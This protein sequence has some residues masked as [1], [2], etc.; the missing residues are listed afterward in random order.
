MRKKENH[1]LKDERKYLPEIVLGGIDGSIT[2]FAVVSG[3]VG[4]SLNTSIVLIMG[5]AN[6]FADGFSMAVSDFFSVKSNNDTSKICPY[7][8]KNKTPTQ[9]AFATFL[10]FL[11]I[12]FIPLLSFVFS[13]ITKNYFIVSNQFLISGILT[14]LSFLIVGF[15]RGDVLGKNKFKSSLEVLLTGGIAS[16]LA[17]LAGRILHFIL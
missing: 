5:F 8:E 9:S 6:L 10:A 1:I 7:D 12:G 11:I 17:F 14:G 16:I 2:T 13:L 15:F 4:A 3:V